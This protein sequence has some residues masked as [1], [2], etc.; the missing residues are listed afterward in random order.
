MAGPTTTSEGSE[1]E[2]IEALL[3]W[4][5]AGTLRPDELARVERYI[6]RHPELERL[7]ELARQER[8]GVV[9]GNEAL[10]APGPM[11]LERLMGRIAAER[12][13]EASAGQRSSLLTRVGEWIG[14]LAQSLAPPQLAM[15]AAAALALVVVQG[16]TIGVLTGTR[17]DG[18]Y[19][20]ASGGK[21]APAAAGTFALVSFTPG[22]T[23][24]S[25]SE[26]LS[27]LDASIV[28]GPKAGGIYRVRLSAQVLDEAAA[29]EV[30]SRLAARG[31]LV[32][33]AALSE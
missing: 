12:G 4:Y 27:A 7:V 25:I 18:G 33:F 15:V 30:L 13:S 28:E 1:R 16:V 26:L 6:T 19:V 22:A 31:D 23:A 21:D 5:V 24:A 9:E 20:T 11:A 10:G 8:A 2:E 29:K 32:A 3:P 14:G 17:H